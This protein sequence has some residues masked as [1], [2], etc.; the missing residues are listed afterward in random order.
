MVGLIDIAPAIESV[1]V[2]GTSVT[3]H[4]VSAK[5]LASLL[6]RFPEL[7][8]LMTGQEVQTE[9]LMAMGGDAVAAVIAAG[10]GYPGDEAAET[11]AG[12]LS[13]DAQADLLAAI[14]RLTLPKGVGPFV[15]EKLTRSAAFSVPTPLHPIRGRLRNRGSSRRADWGQLSTGRGVGN[16]ATPNAL[17]NCHSLDLRLRSSGKSS[18]ASRRPSAGSTDL[19]HRLASETI[20]ARKLIHHLDQAVLA[21]AFRGELVPQDPNDEPASVLLERMRAECAAAPAKVKRKPKQIGSGQRV[22]VSTADSD[23]TR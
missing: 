13:L 7:R 1:D 14:L 5:G 20:K 19:L 17:R 12:K 9:Q 18:A 21:K 23:R 8:M 4:G 3:V 2:Q 11:V 6:G 10:C 15:G 22:V 16:D